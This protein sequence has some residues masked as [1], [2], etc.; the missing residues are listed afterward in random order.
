MTSPSLYMTANTMTP[1][2][3]L[4]FIIFCTFHGLTSGQIQPII[5]RIPK[6][7]D[8]KERKLKAV[9]LCPCCES[10][11]SAKAGWMFNRPWTAMCIQNVTRQKRTWTPSMM[12]MMASG[13]QDFPGPPPRLPFALA[14]ECIGQ[15]GAGEV[16]KQGTSV[17]ASLWT[18][19]KQTSVS[20]PASPRPPCLQMK[21]KQK[22]TPSRNRCGTRRGCL[23]SNAWEGKALILMND[24]F[25]VYVCWVLSIL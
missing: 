20:L 8:C 22:N 1:W 7:V 13:E 14:E 15:A 12:M 21:G 9:V 17:L 11:M 10:S 24:S 16:C 5:F 3:L 2:G 18:H 4:Y 19:Q 23:N 6:A 25:N